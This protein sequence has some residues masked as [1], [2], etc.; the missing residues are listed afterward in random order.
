MA[1]VVQVAAE[2][3][4]YCNQVAATLGFKSCTNQKS[5][6]KIYHNVNCKRNFLIYLMECSLCKIEYAGKAETSSNFFLNNQTSNVS[7]PNT[8]HLY[9]WRLLPTKANQLK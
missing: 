3:A 7:D 5:S 8:F 1:N 6:F 2:K 9:E 4:M